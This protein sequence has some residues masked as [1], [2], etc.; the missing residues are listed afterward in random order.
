MPQQSPFSRRLASAIAYL[1]TL[2][3]S[4]CRIRESRLWNDQLSNR[5]QTAIYACYG[6]GTVGIDSALPPGCFSTT[7]KNCVDKA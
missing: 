6:K 7:R 2:P 5:P 3:S 4:V 1:G